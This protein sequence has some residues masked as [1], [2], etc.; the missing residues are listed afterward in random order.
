MS[1]YKINFNN[2]KFSFGG[3]EIHPEYVPYTFKFKNNKKYSDDEFETFSVKYD[4]VEIIN[5]DSPDIKDFTFEFK[6]NQQLNTFEYVI[7]SEAK[8][9]S[10]TQKL[11]E[12]YAVHFYY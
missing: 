1:K 5:K 4:D 7:N 12:K 6:E 9:N 3:V 8:Y 2:V 11:C 10:E